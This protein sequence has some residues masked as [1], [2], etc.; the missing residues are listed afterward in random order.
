MDCSRSETRLALICA[1]YMYPIFLKKL[2]IIIITELTT[3]IS[4]LVT[5]A[6]KSVNKQTVQTLNRLIMP[7]LSLKPT[8]KLGWSFVLVYCRLQALVRLRS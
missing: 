4:R 2:C 7:I 1:N 3:H 5:R 8:L 6:I